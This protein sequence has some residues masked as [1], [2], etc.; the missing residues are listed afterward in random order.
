MKLVLSR[1]GLDSS[2]GNVPSPIL[3]DGRICWI[4]IPENSPSKPGLPTYGELSFGDLNLGDVV[5]SLSSGR[6]TRHQSVHLDPDIHQ[7]WRSLPRRWHPGFGQTGAAEKHLRNHNISS[8]DLFLYFGWFR[9]TEWVD[10]NLKFVRKSPDLHLL[11]GWLLVGDRISVDLLADWPDGLEHHP[12]RIGNP[13]GLLDAIYLPAKG[14]IT[15]GRNPAYASFGVFERIRPELVLTREGG[16]RS[17]WALP[18]DFAPSGRPPLSYHA[19]PTRWSPLDD[20]TVSLK[21]VSRGQ[22][23]VLDVDHYPGVKHW[24][25]TQIF[26]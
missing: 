5:E 18:R 4:P 23:F 2:F 12:H 7:G 16:T 21:L 6:L 13:Y 14:G 17:E 26:A 11:Y 19:D 3:P 25:D 9:Q 24:L 15:F 8:G 10:G 1:K 22:E 20:E